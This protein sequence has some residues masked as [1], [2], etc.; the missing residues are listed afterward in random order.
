MGVQKSS[1]SDRARQ[2]CSTRGKSTASS[3]DKTFLTGSFSVFN[4]NKKN[5]DFNFLNQPIFKD[6]FDG[7]Q[8]MLTII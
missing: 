6:L 4:K 7:I 5:Q 8:F 3:S 2:I 1:I